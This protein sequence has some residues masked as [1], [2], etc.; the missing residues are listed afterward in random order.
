[1]EEKIEEMKV[2]TGCNESKSISDTLILKHFSGPGRI[3]RQDAPERHVP[4]APAVHVP[5]VLR[6]H[7]EGQRVSG[8]GR[9]RLRHAGLG[10]GQGGEGRYFNVRINITFLMNPSNYYYFFSFLAFCTTLWPIPMSRTPTRA[11]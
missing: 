5:D 2:G 6:L 1:M 4:A 9:L 3:P 10:N 11:G 8:Q 7:R